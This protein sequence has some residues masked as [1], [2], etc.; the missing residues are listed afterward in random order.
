MFIGISEQIESECITFK[1][2]VEPYNDDSS[3]FFQ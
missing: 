2:N 3:F 1:Y